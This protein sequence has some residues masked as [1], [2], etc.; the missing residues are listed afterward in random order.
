[1]MPRLLATTHALVWLALV[2]APV[3][4]LSAATPPPNVI[5]ILTDDQGAADAGCYGAKDLETPAIDA[6]AARGVR[7]TQFYSAAPVCSPARAGLLTGK[8]PLRAGLTGNASSQPGGKGLPAAQVTMAEMFKAAG[9]TTGHFGK[10]HLGYRP[11]TM[12]NAQGFDHSFGHMGGCIDNFSHFFYWQG[13]NR[14]DLYLNGQEI[15][16]PGRHFADMMVEEA[17]AFM[18]K[19][20]AQP[21]FIYFA[22]NMPHYPYQGDPKWLERYQ[23]LPYPRNLY[24]AFLSSCDERIGALLKKV[25]DLGLREKTIVVFQSDN[26]HSTEE[27]AHF[28]GGSAGPYRGQ[29]FSLFEGGIRLPGIVAWPGQL[30]AG[31]VRDQIAHA[32]DWLPTLA[33]LTGVKIID[34]DL[35]GKSLVPVLRSAKAPSPHAVL[36]WLVGV[37]GARAQWAVRAGDWKLISNVSEAPAT[38]LTTADKKLFLA[39]LATDVTESRNLAGQNPEVVQRLQKLHDDWLAAQSSLLTDDEAQDRK[40]NEK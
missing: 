24:A 25:E 20:R 40:G 27:R 18:S 13:P 31:A 22:L 5:V 23:H 3:T 28:G 11:E 8:Y 34:A 38:N 35:D 29:K 21:F 1:M 15:Q 19:H 10:W 33:E 6:L 14:H 36:H 26:G 7:F 2:N 37:G 32:C 9:Y 30:P 39:N 17:T 16:R 4:P 12:P